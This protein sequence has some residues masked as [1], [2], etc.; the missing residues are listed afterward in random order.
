MDIINYLFE[1]GFPDKKYNATINYPD[2]N[3]INVKYLNQFNLKYNKK[4]YLYI[5]SEKDDIKNSDIDKLFN[6]SLNYISNI[7]HNLF[8]KNIENYISGGAALKLYSIFSNTK[9]NEK[10]LNT[11]DYDLY[12]YYDEKKITNKIIFLNTIKII[13]SILEFSDK[14]NY[15]FLELYMIINFENTKKFKEVLEIFFSNNFDLYT[16]NPNIEKNIYLFSFLKIINKEFC[17]RLRI[18]F[19]KMDDRLLKENI[20]SYN[21]INFYYINKINNKFISVNKYIPIEILVKNK[22]KSNIE[23]MKYKLKIYKYDFYI[24]NKEALLYNLMH[25]YYKY[26]NITDD[27]T[28]YNRINERKKEGKDIRDEKRLN[29]FFLIY[30]KLKNLNYS[31]NNITEK[32]NKLKNENIKFKK[33]IENIKDLSFINNIISL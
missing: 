25:L 5:H 26:N 28:D 4:K 3:I 18:K 21:K 7:Q 14:Q 22:N 1:Y 6:E 32:L 10:I 2:T 33:S 24:Y 16:Y 31:T 15:A 9:D 13:N 23:I 11:K 30:I 19:L 27:I 17:I 12:L 20:Y 8:K 29:L